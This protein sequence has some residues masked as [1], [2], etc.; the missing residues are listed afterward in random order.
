[1]KRRQTTKL[2]A[3]LFLLSVTGAFNVLGETDD[4][5][6]DISK[7]KRWLKVTPRPHEVKATFEALD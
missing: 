1:M 2:I 4:Y 3:T 7:Y 6:N 5:Q